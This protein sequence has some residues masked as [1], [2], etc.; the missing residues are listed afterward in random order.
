[1]GRESSPGNK[2][3]LKPTI[4]GSQD[5]APSSPT[6]SCCREKYNE[7]MDAS[8]NRKLIAELAV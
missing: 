2:I 1:M 7:V 8:L 4:P 3:I 5:Q 6:H